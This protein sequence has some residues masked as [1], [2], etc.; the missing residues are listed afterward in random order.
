MKRPDYQKLSD[1]IKN[2]KRINIVGSSGSGKSTFGKKLSSSVGIPY[3]EMDE[4]FW[5]PNWYR[6]EKEEFYAKIE[7]RITGDSWILDGNYSKS[8]HVKWKN[9][10]TVIWLDYPYPRIIFQTI[11]RAISRIISQQ[12]MWP[13]TENKESFRR[14]FLSK[15]S[16]ILWSLSN[17]TKVRKKYKRLMKDPE[18]S[19]INFIRL[20]SNKHSN[21]LLENIQPKSSINS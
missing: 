16:I 17:L 11:R 21:K 20:K 7:N 6:P 4:I 1:V 13:G 15:E 14:A 10:Q 2:S 19:H 3:I 5:G 8:T 9:V 12:E 18:Y